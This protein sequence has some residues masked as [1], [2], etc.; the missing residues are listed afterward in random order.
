MRLLRHVELLRCRSS[1]RQPPHSNRRDGTRHA[2][3]LTGRRR[4]LPRSRKQRVLALAAELGLERV[5][6][7]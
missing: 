1:R 2:A 3:G 7:V 4:I 5:A 6:Q